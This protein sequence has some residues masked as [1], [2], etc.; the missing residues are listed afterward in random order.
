MITTLKTDITIKD[1]CE[2]FV[3]NEFEGRGLF[4]LSGKLTIQPEYQRN[5]IYA[6]DGGKREMAVIES[7]LKEYPL[8]LIYFNKVSD[9]K[10]EVLDGQQRITSIGRFVNDQFAIKDKNGM[11]QYF[12]G[13]AKDKQAKIWETKLLIYECKGEESEI[14]E[15]FETINIAG[16]PLTPQELLNAIYSGPFVTLAKEEFSNSQ[17]SNIQKWSAYIKGSANRQE[18]L[19]C[20]LDWVSRNNIGGYMSSHRNEKNIIELKTYFNKV[21]DWISIVFI[22]V[23]NEMRGL[24]WGRLYEQYHEQKYD[25]A[26][27]SAEVQKLYS[28]PYIKNRKGVFEYILGGSVDTKLLEVRVFDEATKKSVYTSQT[29]ESET[30]GKSNCPLCSLGHDAN[31]KKIWKLDEMDAD[32]VAAWSRGGVTSVENCQMLCKT[33]NR[34]KGNR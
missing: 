20:A 23:E 14:K 22:D 13:M 30:K 5:Y 1:I 21:I 16:V 15:W 9:D 8:G 17:N 27:V 29:K 32:H 33:H 28:D 4:G 19:E 26:K 2:G 12:S 18:F 10:F 24:E 34:A 6:S 25:P 3:Y 7:I 11:E 31:K